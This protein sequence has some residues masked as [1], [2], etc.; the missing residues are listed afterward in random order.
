MLIIMNLMNIIKIR[1]RILMS[2][3]NNIEM[4]DVISVGSILL[5]MVDVVVNRGRMVDY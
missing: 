1:I 2:L 5:D 4:G 3:I